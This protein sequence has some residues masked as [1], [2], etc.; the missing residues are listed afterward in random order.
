VL[1]RECVQRRLVDDAQILRLLEEGAGI[2]FSKLCQFR[3]LL[4]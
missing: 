4:S 3:S 1:G 2:E